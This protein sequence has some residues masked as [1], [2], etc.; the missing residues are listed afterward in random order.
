MVINEVMDYYN[1]TLEGF[2]IFGSYARR[3]NRKNS[4]LDLLIILKEAP[5]FSKR[6]REFVENIEIKH[7]HI[8]QKLYEDE[9]INCD[10]SPYILSYD[11]ALKLQP[12]YFDL[13]EH[14]IIIF[15]PKKIIS[16]II[17]STKDIIYKSNAKKTSYGN[18]FEWNFE[19]VGFL[20]GSNL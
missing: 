20:G 17:D 2:A 16:R 11:E 4:D 19:D 12:I 15:D 5:G 10:L 14:N 13:V 6:I 1:E 18:F 9:E 8:A 3:E 7:E